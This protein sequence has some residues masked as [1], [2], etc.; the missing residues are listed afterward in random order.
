MSE[1]FSASPLVRERVTFPAGGVHLEGR[2]TY[3]E[4]GVPKSGV[5]LLSPHP[6]FAGDLDN[7]VI[8]ALERGLGARG[9]AAL[10][11]NYRGIGGSGI[12]LAAASSGSIHDPSIHDPSIHDYWDRVE[13]ETRYEEIV[14]DAEAARS[15]LAAQLPPGTPLHLVG[16]SFGAVLAALLI[17]AR[18][19]ELPPPASL[20][21]VAPPIRRYPLPFLGEL[22][23]PR[24]LVLAAEDFLYGE[25][26]IAVL[27]KLTPPLL[28]EVIPG[29]DHFFR[30]REDEAVHRV[31]M[32]VAFGGAP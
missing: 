9:L 8:R 6:H 12:D 5:L 18:R 4:A 2:L 28:I 17:R 21:L 25:A 1:V 15:H 27:E 22:P 10:A 14:V 11:F 7:N 29:A 13:R 20:T 24:L 26:E 23:L 19:N 16:Y 31:A 3:P 30:G 32:F